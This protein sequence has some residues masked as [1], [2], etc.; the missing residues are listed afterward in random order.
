M[1]VGTGRQCSDYASRLELEKGKQ[2]VDVMVDA[3]HGA[4]NPTVQ[5]VVVVGWLVW[6]FVS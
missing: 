2:N 1:W 4:R 5:P 3:N 6:F